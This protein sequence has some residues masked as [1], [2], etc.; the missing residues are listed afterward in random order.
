MAE[1]RRKL[2]ILVAIDEI[3]DP[4]WERFQALVRL[5]FERDGLA[6]Y[7]AMT[8]ERFDAAFIDLHLTGVDSLELL[9]RART[10]QLCSNLILTSSAPSF[11]YAQQ[12]ILYGVLAYLLRPLQAD[13]V[14]EVIRRLQGI[15]AIPDRSV[16]EA[17]K[18]VAA[19]LREDDTSEVF[20]QAGRALVQQTGDPI[21]EKLRWRSL[22]GETVNRVFQLY[23]WLALYHNP[24]EYE[25]LD[26]IQESDGDIVVS[27][28]LRKLRVL[29]ENVRE[30]FPRPK[31]AK[32]EEIL[33]LLLETVDENIQQKDVADRYFIT[34]STLSTRFQRNL[35]ISYRTYITRVKIRR[36]Q[37][38]LRN[39]D[40]APDEVAARLGYKDKEYF[41]RLFLQHT[42]Q[43]I[44]ECAQKAWGE[45]NI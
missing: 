21:E 19:S 15:A 11:T 18:A 43:T 22:Y 25:A 40:I 8:H 7:R 26:Y 44:Q 17:A 38:L 10:E 2:N 27:F 36:G 41:S 39:T 1:A 32:M 30:L 16:W 33:I 12:G 37:Y 24:A 34:N 35:G 45:Y 13:E 9:R 14:A 42:G 31:T 4:V 5:H 3:P 6:A 29:S 20:L 23:P 28:C